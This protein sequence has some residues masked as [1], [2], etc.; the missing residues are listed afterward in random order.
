MLLRGRDPAALLE[1]ARRELHALDLELPVIQPGT[2]TQLVDQQLAQ[3][4]FYLVLLGLLAALAVV[5]AAVGMYGVVAYVVSQRT[6]EI[7][8]RMALG[9]RAPQVVQLVLWQGV[10]PAILGIVLGVLGALWTG[11]LMRG[12]L[13]EVAPQDP[14]TLF[15]VS[16]L[17][18]GV[19]VAACAI[20]ARRATRV[21]P[22][23]ALRSE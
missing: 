2:L 1:A 20:P 4:R 19:V 12:L 8:V 16:L 10:R 5:L 15:V 6:K 22:A 11:S 23:T 13:Y 14:L 7:G 17:L 21:A 9:A 3:P 18:L